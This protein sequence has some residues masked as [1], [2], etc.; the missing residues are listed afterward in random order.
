VA[1]PHPG[2]A[3]TN[4][5]VLRGRRADPAAGHANCALGLR[6]SEL[7][8]GFFETLSIAILEGRAFTE[9]DVLGSE[10]VVIVSRSAAEAWWPGESA[11]GRRIRIGGPDSDEPWLRVVGV[12]GD[13]QRIHTMSRSYAANG[14]VQPRAFRPAAQTDDDPP[15]GW[16]YR[17]CFFCGRISFAIRPSQDLHVSIERIRRDLTVVAPELYVPEVRTLLDEQMR[18]WG[19]A[20]LASGMRLLGPF[21]LLA[22]GLALLGIVG[23]TTDGVTRRTRE[24]GIRTAIG[25]RRI[26]VVALMASQCLVA[27]AAGTV[28]GVGFLLL[29]V[30]VTR[31]VFFFDTAARGT[32]PG[33]G[34]DRSR[35][36]AP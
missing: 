35:S 20:N 11:L 27:A 12:V 15:A 31:K 7:S 34:H 18:R 33:T 13:V 3:T 21:A 26:Q 14:L 22:A 5:G 17:R 9:L 2:L 30:S 19:P 29:G 24:I 23:V 28:A 16:T 36:P 8:Y 6:R 32:L 25:A 10:P 4:R 1:D